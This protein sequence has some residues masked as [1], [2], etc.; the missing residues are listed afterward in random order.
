MLKKHLHLKWQS[1]FE[2]EI[3]CSVAE[4]IFLPSTKEFSPYKRFSLMFSIKRKNRYTESTC[5]S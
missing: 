3:E 5:E 4:L 1:V 2:I